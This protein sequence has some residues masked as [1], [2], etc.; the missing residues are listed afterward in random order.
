MGKFFDYLMT[1]NW[2]ETQRI[3]LYKKLGKKLEPEL[4]ES[5]QPKKMSFGES[6]ANLSMAM[7]Q[8][9]L[10]AKQDKERKN[11]EKNIS[12]VNGRGEIVS[13]PIN[14]SKEFDKKRIR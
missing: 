13:I 2:E 4:K 5:E 6:M 1:G 11:N 14:K 9:R 3:A 7:A 12:Y 8:S 10:K